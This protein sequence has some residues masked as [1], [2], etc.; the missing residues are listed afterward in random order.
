[1]VQKKYGKNKGNN[2]PN[3]STNFKRKKVNKANFPCFT[4]GELG[5]LSKD[6]SDCVDRRGKLAT[7][8]WCPRMSTW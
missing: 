2:K 3:K 1:M 6:Y 8:D 7:M 5:R 4:C